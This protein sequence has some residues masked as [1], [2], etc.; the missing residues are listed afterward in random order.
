MCGWGAVCFYGVWGG[1]RP[2]TIIIITTTIMMMITIITT[3]ISMI[4]IIL[5]G[6][7]ICT[8]MYRRGTLRLGVCWRWV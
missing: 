7:R 4:T 8:V 5:M 1:F 2:H 3:T 6:M